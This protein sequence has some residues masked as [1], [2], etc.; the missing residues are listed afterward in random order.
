MGSKIAF[1]DAVIPFTDDLTYY[2]VLLTQNK[3]QAEDLV[4]DCLLNAYEGW[5]KFVYVDDVS[6]KN[7]II[8]ILKNNFINRHRINQIRHQAV[9]MYSNEIRNQIMPDQMSCQGPEAIAM[10]KTLDYEIGQAF[11]ILP[12]KLK[13]VTILFIINGYSYKEIGRVTGLCI[14][15]VKSRIRRGKENLRKKLRY[16]KGR[17]K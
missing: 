6:C 16:L 10:S 1:K 3:E 9:T 17:C 12:E 15:T 8:T 7:W 2:A 14:N 5:N 4:Q 13:L 11:D